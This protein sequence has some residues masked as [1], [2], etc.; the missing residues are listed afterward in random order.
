M[1]G[2]KGLSMG[3]GAGEGNTLPQSLGSTLSWEQGTG[4]FN[5][6]TRERGLEGSPETLPML[7]RMLF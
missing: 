2:R 5:P 6:A 4:H 3:A 7:L 1:E